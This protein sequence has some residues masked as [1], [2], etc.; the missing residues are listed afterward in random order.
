MRTF[1]H[2]GPLRTYLR[3]LRAEGKTVGFVPTMGALHA[4]HLTLIR[5]AKSDC[6]VTVISVFVNPT[7]FGPHEDFAAY[8]R[9][10]GRDQKLASDEGVD[11]LFAPSVEELYPAGFQTSVE[12]AELSAV[13]EGA[14][15]PGHFRGVATV[16]TK[17]FNIVQPDRAYFGQKDYQQLLLIERLVRD[18]NIPT[19]IVPVP[20]V[21]EPDGLAMSSRNAYLSPEERRAATVLYRALQRAEELVKAGATDPVQVQAE[22]EALIA[23]EPL[24]QSDYVALVHPDTLQPVTTL[25]DAVTLVALAVRI[26]KVRLI[27]NALIAPNGVPIVR[28]RLGKS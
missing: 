10:L 7:Q 6:D 24:A 26:G 11:A 25:A 21:R 16:V 8:P 15:R 22:L 2:I 14:R 17:L 27:D 4:G 19:T 13:L 20:T 23:S 5:R 3:G 18:L 1:E 28:N 9:N 12:V